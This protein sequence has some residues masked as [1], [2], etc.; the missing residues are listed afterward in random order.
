[1][2]VHIFFDCKHILPDHS[3]I[4]IHTKKGEKPFP[5]FL[6]KASVR[7]MRLELTRSCDHYPL[8]VACIPI[9]PPAR[10]ASDAPLKSECPEQDS[11]LHTSRHAHLKRTRL[12][13]PPSGQKKRAE[14]ETRT[15]DPDLGKVVLYQLSYCRKLLNHLL[16]R[17]SDFCQTSA[18]KRMQKY[19]K[20]FNF[21]NIPP[22]YTQFCLFLCTLCYFRF[23][24]HLS[25]CLPSPQLPCP[26]HVLYFVNHYQPLSTILF[27]CNSVRLR[28]RT[29]QDKL[30]G[31]YGLDGCR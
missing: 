19:N 17:L 7:R 1:M 28:V 5:I 9:S 6:R 23:A 27:P 30:Y 15:R 16:E 18:Q 11:N 31:S 4:K 8:K 29:K 3:L 13:I 12:P 21:P 14:N 24:N 10:R 20:F 22:L 25:R 2:A 26:L